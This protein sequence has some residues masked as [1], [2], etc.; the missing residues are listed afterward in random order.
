MIGTDKKYR[1]GWG[2]N[3]QRCARALTD[4]TTN[5]IARLR[6]L[7]FNLLGRKRLARLQLRLA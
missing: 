6:H 3:L 1:D 2:S 4:L 7:K 5:S